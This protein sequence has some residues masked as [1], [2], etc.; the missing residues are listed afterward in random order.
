MGS[1]YQTHCKHGHPFT[2]ENTLKNLL[3]SS[4]SSNQKHPHRT[5]A[6]RSESASASV[7]RSLGT[8]RVGSN[9]ENPKRR[10]AFASLMGIT[11]QL[12]DGVYLALEVGYLLVASP[13]IF[14]NLNRKR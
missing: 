8:R 12:M 1:K 10:H 5:S 14:C 3:P 4:I 7:M 6:K 2:P 9:L 11:R 13:L